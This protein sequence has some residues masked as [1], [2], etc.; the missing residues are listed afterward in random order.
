MSGAER[1]AVAEF[2]AGRPMAGDVAGSSTGRKIR[3]RGRGMAKPGGETGDLYAEIRVVLPETL[4]PREEELYKELAKVSSFQPRKGET[5][6][7]A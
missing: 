2:A 7:D 3:L 1:R 5:T 4:S 6:S